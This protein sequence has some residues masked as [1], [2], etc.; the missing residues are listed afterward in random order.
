MTVLKARTYHDAPCIAN[1]GWPRQ[2]CSSLVVPTSQWAAKYVAA[3]GVAKKFRLGGGGAD[4][5][6]SNYLPPILISPRILPTL[7]QKYWKILQILA[8]P[9]MAILANIQKILFKHHGFWGD[10]PQNFKWGTCPHHP[11][12]PNKIGSWQTYFGLKWAFSHPVLKI[13]YW[14]HHLDIQNHLVIHFT[15]LVS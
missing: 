15:D 4:S 9:N 13:F 6:Q 10:I 3:R 7:F 12:P 8:N 11:P 1:D 2:R 5:G 14:T